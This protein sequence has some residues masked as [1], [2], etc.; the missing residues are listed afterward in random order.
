MSAT[1]RHAIRVFA[2]HRALTALTIVSLSLGIGANATIFSFL[3]AALLRPLP[4]P[5]ADRLVSILDTAGSNNTTPTIPEMLDVRAWNK[6]L[7]GVSF[8]DT[9]DM[10]IEGA[11]EPTRVLA[12]RVEPAMLPMIGARPS[13]GGLFAPGDGAVG[14]R[15]TVILSDGL[16]RR[17]FGGDQSVI[18]R[19]LIVDG[20]ACTIAG[21]LAPD[22]TLDVLSTQPIE[23]YVP[24]P[25]TPDYT[26]RE[27]AFSSVR[28]VVA[29][30]R[31][32]PGVSLT[33][34]A[35]DLARISTRLIEQHPALYQSTGGPRTSARFTMTAE[36][37]HESVVRGNRTLA[38]LLQGA[39]ALL[40]LIA[41]ANAAQFLLAQAIE[42]EPEIALRRALGAGRGEL[43]RQFLTETLLLGGVA[44]TLGVLQ[45]LWLV[46]VLAALLPPGSRLIGD[47]N[48]DATV[49]AFTTAITVVTMALC[50]LVPGLQFSRDQPPR[51]FENRASTPART[52]TRQIFVAV[53][54]ALSLVLLVQA[55]VLVESLRVLQRDTSGFTADDV[56]V[57][58]MRG[59]GSGGPA[60]GEQYERYLQRL[61][62]VPAVHTAAFTSSVLPGRPG[63]PFTVIGQAQESGSQS[64]RVASW[65]IVSGD[66][67]SVLGIPVLDGR[68][69]DA[70]DRAGRLPAAVINERLAHDWFPG[71][72]AIGRQ[73]RSGIGPRD[74]TMTIV[75]V[76]GNVRPMFQTGDVPQ[77]Y[78]S[79]LQ[80]SEPN[81]VLLLR[82][83]AGSALP[84]DAVKQA[85]WSVEPRQALFGIRSLDETLSLSLQRQRSTSALIGGFAVL[86]LVIS[87]AGI[88]IGISYATSRRVKEIAV[89]RAIGAA[90]RDVLW[91][92]TAQTLS[93]SLAGL[94]AGAGGALLAARA[95]RS[96]V[97]GLVPA[98]AT[99]VG[100]IGLGYLV[101]VAVA[102]MVP[103]RKALRIDPATALRM[104]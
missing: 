28:R 1:I 9:R 15:P 88:G 86:A 76:V 104:E 74:A 68:S 64:A 57:I 95:L 58:R 22:P 93:W 75:G 30:A 17:S 33:A 96:A 84:L 44:A 81:I 12:A 31:L 102:T 65:Q 38:T 47:I 79:Y 45:A 49:L 25:M 92:L 87:V 23:L 4:Y 7:D 101:V 90:N 97:N 69:F 5:D 3:N 20:D 94:A 51:R 52:R 66:Y 27:A 43:V 29:I 16:W 98:D 41:C 80:Q 46:R 19:T 13:L 103:A 53:E 39:V 2:R 71:E 60:L 42:R 54:V 6:T 99:L 14:S 73:I 85:I 55:G 67:F 32:A 82:T 100:V 56:S 91:L 77:I 72:R 10:Q 36:P 35:S 61:S 24:Y 26:S 11:T 34:A 59:M 89:R 21:V 70:T 48:I 40:L 18:G 50:G 83:I 8:F 62:A 63:A 78:V 37:L